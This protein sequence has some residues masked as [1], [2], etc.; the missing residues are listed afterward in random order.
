M[1]TYRLTTMLE[2]VRR[3]RLGA[4][5]ARIAILAARI[6]AERDSKTKEGQRRGA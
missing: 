1:V 4:V 2:D 3:A 5:F 6:R